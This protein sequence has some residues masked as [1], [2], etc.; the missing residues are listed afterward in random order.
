MHNMWMK[1][2]LYTANARAE[3][4]S[5]SPPIPLRH[6]HAMAAAALQFITHSHL[7]HEAHNHLSL[8]QSLHW[9]EQLSC[10][11][12]KHTFTSKLYRQ[13]KEDSGGNNNAQLP[14]LVCKQRRM[15][16]HHHLSSHFDTPH[17]LTFLL[18]PLTA[19][20]A[21]FTNPYVSGTT[22]YYHS[23]FIW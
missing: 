14:S 16:H 5:S 4:D 7:S 23:L 2:V 20:L 3:S 10:Y 6:R 8:Y 15:L 19:T 17:S 21:S 9:L 11:T 12:I 18:P 1:K 13:G 22:Y